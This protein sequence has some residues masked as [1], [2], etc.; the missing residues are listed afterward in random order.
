MIIVEQNIKIKEI[1]VTPMISA[2]WTITRSFANPTPRPFQGKP[3]NS[4]P[5]NHS[6][7]HQA[8]PFRNAAFKLKYELDSAKVE[9]SFF[10][11]PIV[12]AKPPQ[13]AK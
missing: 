1:P 5:L 7:P 2:V 6:K 13:I 4:Q 11:T 8:E 10:G 3:V 9:T 12:A